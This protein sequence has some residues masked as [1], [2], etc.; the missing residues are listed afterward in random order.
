MLN[1]FIFI[2]TLASLFSDLC[3]IIIYWYMVGGCGGGRSVPCTAA[4]TYTLLIA[5]KSQYP[6]PRTLLIKLI[7]SSIV[8]WN[9]GV[10]RIHFPRRNFRIWTRN[11]Y[12]RREFIR[13]GFGAVKK[14]YYWES[15]SM[16]NEGISCNLIEIGNGM[17]K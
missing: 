5:H 4:D 11:Q 17:G 16:I 1:H 12:G 7:L 3:N 8:R 13:R 14:W 15:Y 2:R 9:L 6:K 10:P